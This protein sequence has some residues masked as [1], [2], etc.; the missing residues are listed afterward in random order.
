M[1]AADVGLSLIC[2]ACGERFIAA[3][4]AVPRPREAVVAPVVPSPPAPRRLLR[5][6][7]VGVGVGFG[8]GIAGGLVW[9][10]TRPATTPAAAT[11]SPVLPPVPTVFPVNPSRPAVARP[12]GPATAVTRPTTPVSRPST[13]SASAR[14]ATAPATRPATGPAT[15]TVAVTPAGL[16][17]RLTPVRPPPPPP[18][19][20][21][22][23]GTAIN[24]GITRLAG[25]FDRLG[26][27]PAATDGEGTPAGAD[28]LAVYAMLTAAQAVDRPDLAVSQPAVG[29]LLD[30]L[31]LMPM[32]Q[33]YTTY[34]RSLRAAALAVY[35]RPADRRTLQSD[36]GFLAAQQQ[37]GAFTYDAQTRGRVGRPLRTAR[38]VLPAGNWDNS[39]SQYGALGVWA[40]E[41]AGVEVQTRFWEEVRQHWLATQLATGEWAY[42]GPAG[43]G[44]LSMTV[45]GVTTVL[46]A[47][48]QIGAAAA[49]GPA[50]R[51]PFTPP[52]ARGMR[53]L[54]AGDHAV[55]LP[56]DWPAYTLYG[57]ERAALASGYKTFGRHDWYPELAQGRLA[58]QAADGSWA[59]S[60]GETDGG[61]RAVVDT[62]YSLLFLARGRHPILMDKL[63]FAGSWA[64]RPGD[65]AHLTRFASKVLE[66]SF[67]WQVVS[68]DDPWT[69]W[70][71]APVLYIASHEPPLFTADQVDKL[72]SFA[73]AGGLIFTTNDGASPPFDAA[74]ADL[75]AK[76]FPRYPLRDLA[77]DDPVY[78]TVFPLDKAGADA[79]PPLRGVSNGSRWLLLHSPTDVGKVWQLRET[80]TRPAP[81][82]LGLNV[83]IYAAGKTNFRNKLHAAYLPE[84]AVTPVGRTT[85]ARVTYDGDWDPEPAA[86]GRFARAFLGDTSLHVAIADVDATALDV[87]TTPLAL[88]T[89]T[90]P[91]RLTSQQRQAL[92]DYVAAGGV[93]LAD[94]CGGSKAGR[95]SLVADVLPH[96]F[97]EARLTDLPADHPILAGTGR[98]MSPA[99]LRLR[100][101]AALLEGVRRRPV[102]SAAVGHGRVLFCPCDVTTGLLGTATWGVDG[103]DADA[104]YALARNA[105]LWSVERTPTDPP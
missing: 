82:Q 46:V 63:R 49:V 12:P 20:D 84:P 67:N 47:E 76:L 11:T 22:R 90:G 59:D 21:D 92:H 81:F 80:V 26:L 2:P 14:P 34:S 73:Q 64:N 69:S 30:G 5:W 23:I 96:T 36:A 95:D 17:P 56:A 4:P 102:Q 40:A 43:A 25:Q 77:A 83:F 70:T 42:G 51:S 101:Y 3:V 75:A 65:L 19:L 86:A 44:Q 78:G 24:R 68:V 100:P 35:G 10:A 16:S 104:A 32:A 79:P 53:W 89:G 37:F 93:L 15:T 54:E 28:A 9:L 29:R 66:R 8:M 99:T 85:V 27:L 55:T 45:A 38:G 57:I 87:R 13:T 62:A 74:V 61:D 103:Y 50:G 18:D 72:R 97:P 94:A 33:R 39:N 71:D 7:T 6:A 105:L 41:D 98:G 48:D 52:V 91:V 58:A 1:A 88:L 60:T 31:R